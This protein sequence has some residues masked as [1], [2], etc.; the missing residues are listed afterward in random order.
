MLI[1]A[2]RSLLLLIDLQERLAPA[3]DQMEQ[4]A[5]HNLWLLRLAQRLSVPVAATVQYPAGL[6]AMLP[7]LAA[8]VAPCNIVEKIHFSAVADGC[9]PQLADFSRPQII[10][11]GTEAHVCVLQ[12]ALDLL[13]AGK[14]VFVV[15]DAVGSRRAENRLLALER[16]RQEGCR[17]VSREMVAYEWLH[18]AGTELFRE[19]NRTFLR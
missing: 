19:I 2:H 12:T 9:L 7:E 13:S 1:D 17:I 18:R 15:A 3:I 6:G 11:T 10:L 4:V 8:H 5:Q 14:E 16:L